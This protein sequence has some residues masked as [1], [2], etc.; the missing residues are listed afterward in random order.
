MKINMVNVNWA[1][2][3][4]VLFEPYEWQEDDPIEWLFQVEL[5]HVSSLVMHDCIEAIVTFKDLEKGYYLISDGHLS[6]AIA[7]DQEHHLCMRST[8]DY[9]LRKKIQELISFLPMLDIIYDISDYQQTKEYGLTRFEKEKK[10]LLLAYLDVFDYDE[11]S[12]LA[13]NDWNYIENGYH[14]F[15]EY[16]Y[17]QICQQKNKKT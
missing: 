1:Y 13:S 6:L 11:I 12:H 4:E 9:S 15:H 8:L 16:L 10:Q 7:V 14:L 3:D 2:E 5:L 17:H